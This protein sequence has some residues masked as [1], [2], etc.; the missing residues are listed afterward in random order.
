VQQ[1]CYYRTA[2]EGS[3]VLLKNMTGCKKL[4]L[5]HKSKI[6]GWQF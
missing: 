2:M 3:S 4:E 6:C 1:D 5:T